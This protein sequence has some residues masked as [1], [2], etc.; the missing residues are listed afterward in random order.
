[1]YRR[2]TIGQLRVSNSVPCANNRSL[3]V[4]INREGRQNKE[5]LVC[6]SPVPE[7]AFGNGVEP[8]SNGNVSPIVHH[9]GTEAV[10]RYSPTLPLTSALEGLGD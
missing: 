1:V 9:E 8:D 4:I 7:L 5:N 6:P 2:P 10:L 3:S